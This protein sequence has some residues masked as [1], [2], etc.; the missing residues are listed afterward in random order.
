VSAL[1]DILGDLSRG[2]GALSTRAT[3]ALYAAAAAA[4]QPA[5]HDWAASGGQS[6]EPLLEQAIEVGFELAR[7]GTTET[8]LA[9]ILRRLELATPT[10]VAADS[11]PSTAAQDCLICADVALRVHVEPTF[12]QGPV[13][14][15]ALEPVLMAATGRVSA[16]PQPDD[17]SEAPA[18]ADALLEDSQ[19]LAAVEFMWFALMRL[20]GKLEPDPATIDAIR[21][22]A[23]VLLP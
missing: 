19:V 17:G 23:T 4:L 5:F 1:D 12:A 10:R 7:S 6:T 9:D 18:A 20:R 13:I 15:Y 3:S 11:A 8:D 16:V 21:T 14:E 2:V 22:R